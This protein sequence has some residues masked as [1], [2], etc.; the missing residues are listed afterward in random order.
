MQMSKP[1][2]FYASKG[3]LFKH[4]KPIMVCEHA[5]PLTKSICKSANATNGV[6]NV[7]NV[8]CKT[9]SAL[10]VY[11]PSQV[12][13]RDFSEEKVIEGILEVYILEK[14]TPINS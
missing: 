6:S 4:H 8:N 7:I 3:S 1:V 9:G 2:D 10:P 13:R 14:M 11:F 12:W 5:F